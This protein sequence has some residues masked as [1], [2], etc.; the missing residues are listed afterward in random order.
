MFQRI[1]GM[2]IYSYHLLPLSSR[3]GMATSVSKQ[4]EEASSLVLEF[5]DS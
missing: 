1:T 2:F 5:G 4:V 3:L